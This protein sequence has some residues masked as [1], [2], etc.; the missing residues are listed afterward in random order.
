MFLFAC[1]KKYLSNCQ[2]CIDFEP[3]KVKLYITFDPYQGDMYLP[4]VINIYEGNI[5]D[6]LLLITTTH[7][8]SPEEVMVTINKKYTVAVTYY[9][10]GRIII[11]VDST[12][13]RVSSNSRDCNKLCYFA[14]DNQADL[15]L[16]YIPKKSAITLSGKSLH[17]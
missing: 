5:E 8:T 7:E 10:Y 11:A 6:S 17:Q 12:I 14:L 3:L 1:D 2:D 15:R 16:K 13:P 4:P 9:Y